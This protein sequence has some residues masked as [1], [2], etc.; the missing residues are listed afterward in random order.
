MRFIKMSNGTYHITTS[1]GVFTINDRSF[2]YNAIVNLLKDKDVEGKEDK[3]LTLLERPDTPNGVF[4]AY[5]SEK[6]NKMYY[7]QSVDTYKRGPVST[8]R[9]IN[10]GSISYA[11]ELGVSTF[12]GV[13]ASIEDII[14]DWPEYA[15]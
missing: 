9:Y 11:D 1:N 8:A 3:V 10:G 14:N 4:E 13:Y 7:I 15:F 6:K 5:I 12:L 2:N